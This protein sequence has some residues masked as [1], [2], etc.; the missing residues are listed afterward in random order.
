MQDTNQDTEWSDALRKHGIITQKKEAEVTE[1]QIVNLIDQAASKHSNG[2]SNMSH[3][4]LDE[5]DLLEDEEDERILLEYRNKRMA[6]I[7]A[8]MAKSK[9]GDVKEISAPEYKEEVNNAGEEVWVVLHLYQHSVPLCKMIN[10]HL[11]TL[12]KKFPTTKFLKSVATNCIPNYPERHVPT[13]FIYNNG[14]MKRQFIGPQE[15][16][17]NSIICGELEWLLSEAG[18]VKTTLESNPR[19]KIQDALFSQLGRSNRSDEDNNDW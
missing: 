13:I 9:F 10:H 12:A 8:L 1:D 7:K 2:Q 18:A 14:Q 15:F 3:L 4:G 16:G 19:P 6:E 11:N 17:R 5:L